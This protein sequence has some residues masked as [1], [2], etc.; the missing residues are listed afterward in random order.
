[1][2]PISNGIID[3]FSD[4]DSHHSLTIFTTGCNFDCYHCYNKDKMKENNYKAREYI[5]K[6]ITTMHT[7]LVILGGEP[8]IHGSELIDFIKWFKEKYGLDVKLFTNGSNYNT[9]KYIV[10]NNLINYFSIDFKAIS[11][12]EDVIGVDFDY[13]E[14]I[15]TINLVYE[16]DIDLEIRTTNLS[17]IDEDSVKEFVTDRWS[18]VEHIVQADMYN[19]LS[20]YM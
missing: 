12:I 17:L 8:T 11:N 5:D 20:D 9:I 3:S 10:D 2:I 6:N 1:M 18:D 4:Y 13:D 14:V 7:G 15:K 19:N 16:S